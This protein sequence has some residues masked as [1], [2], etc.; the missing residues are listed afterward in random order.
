MRKHPCGFESLLRESADGR[1]ELP[2]LR[3]DQGPDEAEWKPP[4]ASRAAMI[5]DRICRLA[6]PSGRGRRPRD[7]GGIRRELSN[8]APSCLGFPSDAVVLSRKVRYAGAWPDL[9]MRSVRPAMEAVP[10]GVE[11]VWFRDE[12]EFFAC[13]LRDAARHGLD[14]WWWKLTFG[15]IPSPLIARFMLFDHPHHARRALSRIRESGLESALRDWFGEQL[16]VDLC[17]SAR[18]ASPAPDPIH[19]V[20]GNRSLAKPHSSKNLAKE[21]RGRE[22]PEDPVETPRRQHET[23]SASPLDSEAIPEQHSGQVATSIRLDNSRPMAG[24]DDF[25]IPTRPGDS[26]EIGEIEVPA[27]MQ[28][29][30]FGYS[31]RAANANARVAVPMGGNRRHDASPLPLTSPSPNNLESEPPAGA[32]QDIDDPSLRPETPQTRPVRSS[33]TSVDEA[34]TP[35]TE[36]DMAPSLKATSTTEWIASPEPAMFRSEF[37]GLFF[38][39][40][41]LLSIGWIA[42]FTRPL[43]L[44]LGLSP[45]TILDHLGRV[46]LGKR[47]LS[48]PLHEWLLA[49]EDS[50]PDPLALEKLRGKEGELFLRLATATGWRAS[51]AFVA[52]SH[53]R[54]IVRDD[55]IC[56]KVDFPLERHSLAI[57]LAGLDRDPG[58][59]ES[60]NRDVRFRFTTESRP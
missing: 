28:D 51:R 35:A 34:T 56:L 39:L 3:S 59:I 13:L 26:W 11:C 8:L 16:W 50:P 21:I 32:R 30:R 46:R 53:R 24:P 2:R 60:G 52:L 47:F 19:A 37:C 29:G 33:G 44:G 5:S 45:W 23:P 58:W 36:S 6:V 9:R 1:L 57:R 25:D 18:L 48:D 43:D 22:Q 4:R 12:T 49:Q 17:G 40:N 27:S 7:I 15:G 41:A 14:T 10:P 55:T 20:T 31:P 42:D 38:T 54:G